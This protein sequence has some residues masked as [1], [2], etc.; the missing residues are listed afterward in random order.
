MFAM[1]FVKSL[2]ATGPLSSVKAMTQCL[3]IHLLTHSSPVLQKTKA[4][5]AKQNKRH[6]QWTANTNKKKQL[7]EH[8]TCPAS[9]LIA[10]RKSVADHG[11]TSCPAPFPWPVWL[12]WGASPS[13]T[14]GPPSIGN[15]SARRW[16]SRPWQPALCSAPRLQKPSWPPWSSH[17]SSRVWWEIQSIATSW[18]KP[19]VANPIA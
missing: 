2:S 12:R 10:I 1:N 16:P 9:P 15:R 8:H 6:E 11:N 19:F 3:A 5:S 7:L 13:A 4:D 14:Q 18:G 17:G